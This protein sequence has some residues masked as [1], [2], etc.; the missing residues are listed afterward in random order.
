MTLEQRLTID[1]LC[2]DAADRPDIDRC[3]VVLGAEENVGSTVPKSDDLVSE[4]FDR[5]AEG[6]GKAKI[7]QLEQ[8]LSIDK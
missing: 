4:V 8:T 5:D 1:N 6:T 2:E 3:R 7:C